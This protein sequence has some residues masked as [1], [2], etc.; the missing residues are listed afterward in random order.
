MTITKLILIHL[1]Q[2]FSFFILGVLYKNFS[3]ENLEPYGIMEN[4]IL[5]CLLQNF[6]GLKIQG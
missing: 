1:S 6:R 3:H 2:I 4:K 5:A